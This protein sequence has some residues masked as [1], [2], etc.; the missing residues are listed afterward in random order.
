VAGFADHLVDIIDG[1][2]E[3]GADLSAL[4]F[5]N[6]LEVDPRLIVPRLQ[7]DPS[8]Q[9]TRNIA[10]SGAPQNSASLSGSTQSI[11]RPFHRVRIPK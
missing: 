5:W 4:T 3:M 1:D 9:T 10:A 8:R 6:R 11:V 2:V 7:L